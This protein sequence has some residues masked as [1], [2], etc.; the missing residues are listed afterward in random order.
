MLRCQSASLRASQALGICYLLLSFNWHFRLFDWIN[1][2]LGPVHQSA[3]WGG[4]ASH[5]LSVR[6]ALKISWKPFTRTEPTNS[7]QNGRNVCDFLYFYSIFF[8]SFLGFWVGQN[9]WKVLSIRQIV[10]WLLS[11]VLNDFILFIFHCTFRFSVVHFTTLQFV[12]LVVGPFFLLLSWM[13]LFIALCAWAIHKHWRKGLT[14]LFQSW[15]DCGANFV[16]LTTERDD[17]STP[18]YLKLWVGH[19]NA[20]NN[21]NYGQYGENVGQTQGLYCHAQK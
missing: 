21:H 3:D 4:A 12:K 14:C 5:H 19:K 8:F 15:W 18:I 9:A 13:T 20:W 16:Q 7:T 6:R 2:G 11:W 10:I 1:D 17:R